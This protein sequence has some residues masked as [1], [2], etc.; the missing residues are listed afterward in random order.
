MNEN[1]FFIQSNEP[2]KAILKLLQIL[3]KN[4]FLL[5]WKSGFTA[6]SN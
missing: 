1:I 5:F 6:S 3:Q 4:I 2:I